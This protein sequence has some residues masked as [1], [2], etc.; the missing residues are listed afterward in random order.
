MDNQ[1]FCQEQ[2]DRPNIAIELQRVEKLKQGISVEGLDDQ[3][4][5]KGLVIKEIKEGSLAKISR[6]MAKNNSFVAEFDESLS[7]VDRKALSHRALSYI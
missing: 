5:K 3:M 4:E 6:R 2:S 7:G 1:C